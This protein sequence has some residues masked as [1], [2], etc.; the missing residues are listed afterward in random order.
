MKVG[1]VSDSHGQ[2]ARLQRA[3]QALCHRGAEVIVHCGDIGGCDCV[4]ELAACGKPTYAVAGNTDLDM[5][6]LQR[7]A[8]SR[9]ITFDIDMVKVHLDG[10]GSL[11]VTHGNQPWLLQKGLSDHVSFLCHG[12]THRQRNEMVGATHIIN[13]GAL[14]RALVPTA[15]LLDTSSG[16]VEFLAVRDE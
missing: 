5:A 12:H 2:K 8:R 16:A 15:A 1:I 4:D 7:Y 10:Q 6:E 14:E 9:G 3:L 11:A 13:P